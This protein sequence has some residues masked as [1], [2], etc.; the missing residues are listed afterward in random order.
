MAFVW[1][2]CNVR[3]EQRTIEGIDN[4]NLVHLSREWLIVMHLCQQQG[5][6]W[7][8]TDNIRHLVKSVSTVH[9]RKAGQ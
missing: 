8:I 9:E 2:I 4:H 5:I 7:K 3:R 6:P 1:Q